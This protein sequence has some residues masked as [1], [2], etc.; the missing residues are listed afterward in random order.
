[1]RK[2]WYECYKEK[3]NEPLTADE[4]AECHDIAF[5]APM[6]SISDFINAM[7][8]QAIED[9]ANGINMKRYKLW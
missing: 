1:M 3:K 7:V 9:I 8:L 2:K 5:G 4:I 6:D